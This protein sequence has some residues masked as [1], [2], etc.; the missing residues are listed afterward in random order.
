MFMKA[1][2]KYNKIVKELTR[3]SFPELENVKVKVHESDNKQFKSDSADVYYFFFYWR[4]R[5]GKKLRKYPKKYIVAILSHE[6]CHISIFQKR[7]FIK[8]IIFFYF[9]LFLKKFRVAEERNAELLEIQ[10]GYGKELSA[11][12]KYNLLI[13]DKKKRKKLKDT[14]YLLRKLN[15]L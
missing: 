8:K 9:L 3:K 4:I 1:V 15:K 13:A 7:N 10:K 14:T 11:F 2:E 6:L 5:L 12:R